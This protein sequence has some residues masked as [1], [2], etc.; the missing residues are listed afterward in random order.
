MKLN[1]KLDIYD[2]L[3]P[4]EIFDNQIIIKDL[5]KLKKNYFDAIMILVP[6]SIIISELSKNLN[7]LKKSKKT[8]IFDIKNSLT[9]IKSNFT[10]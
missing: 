3:V 8:I 5:K 2:P 6:H 1:I 10:L 7:I 9:G 4:N